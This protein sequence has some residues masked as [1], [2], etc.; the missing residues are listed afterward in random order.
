MTQTTATGTLTVGAQKAIPSPQSSPQLV[1]VQLQN[2]SAYNLAVTV[3]P[4][5]F[6]LPPYMTDLY[7]LSATNQNVTVTPSN[8][9][10][11]PDTVSSDVIAT[12]YGPDEMPAQDS[13]P[14]PLT[15]S[16]LALGLVIAEEL[17]QSGIPSTIIETVLA[18][19]VTIPAHGSLTYDVSEYASVILYIENSFITS[20]ARQVVFEFLQQQAPDIPTDSEYLTPIGTAIRAAVTGPTLQVNNSGTAVS[21]LYILGSNRA[22]LDRVD[23]R[24][25]T[26]VGDDWSLTGATLANGSVTV[27]NQADQAAKLQ[28]AV[29]A[30][31]SVSGAAT[32]RF[33]LVYGAGAVTAVLCDTTQMITAASGLHIF[34]KPFAL[35]ADAYAVQ[36]RCVTGAAGVNLLCHLIPAEL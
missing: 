16:Q 13:F 32:G 18:D 10:A 28:G 11:V 20:N 3:G 24:A 19:N 30:A 12:W 8:P 27:L 22:A 4:D 26:A 15:P 9:D 6:N 2:L 36:F 25:N 33:E 5:Q 31:F 14:A 23:T 7:T 21:S 17:L 1:A 29:T 34:D 35:P